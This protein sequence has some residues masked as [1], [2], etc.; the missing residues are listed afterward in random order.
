MNPP[1]IGTTVA[2]PVLYLSSDYGTAIREE[3]SGQRKY[4][5]VELVLPG[6]TPTDDALADDAVAGIFGID[7]YAGADGGSRPPEEVPPVSTASATSRKRGAAATAWQ[8]PPVANVQGVSATGTSAAPA[9][10]R[11]A[12]HGLRPTGKWVPL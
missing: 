1:A 5:V 2:V 9:R 8:T 7:V 12:P 3:W 6:D 4:R 11:A 10:K